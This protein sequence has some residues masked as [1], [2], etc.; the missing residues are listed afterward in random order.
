LA[1]KVI[2]SDVISFEPIPST[3]NRLKRQ[4]DINHVNDMV[5]VINKA[6]GESNKN[7]F[8]TS[9]MDSMNKEIEFRDFDEEKIEVEM[10]KLD[11]YVQTDKQLIIK[12]DVEGNEVNVLKGM[13]VLLK[14]EKVIALIIENNNPDEVYNILKKDY[15]AIDYSPIE[16][17]YKLLIGP[18]LQ[19]ANTIY[20]RK[21][22][23]INELLKSKIELINYLLEMRLF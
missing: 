21:S 1:A 4:L 17:E 22:I 16:K 7:T 10:V 13:N 6:V 14:G 2:E 15:N 19:E 3:I 18:N 20:V 8:F 9:L 23:S 5:M 12:I 11:D